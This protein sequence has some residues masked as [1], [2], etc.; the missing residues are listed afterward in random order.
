VEDSVDRL[1]AAWRRELPEVDLSPL[2][3]LSRI[4]R[5]ARHLDLAR[6]EAFASLGEE[7]GGLAQW[8]FDVLAALRRAGPPYE[9]TPGELVAETLVSS[10]TMTHRIDQMEAAGL[11]ARGDHPHDGRLVRVRLTEQ[12]RRT[13]DAA[14]IGLLARERLLLS[15]LSQQQR[16][17]LATLLKPVLVAFEGP[18]SAP[19]PS[20]PVGPVPDRGQLSVHRVGRRPRRVDR[21]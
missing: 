11:V 9:L 8:Q 5:I 21:A 2:E 10:G 16:S 18:P 1:V 20:F 12:G 7:G 13:V 3:V 19:G 14:L 4:S 6:R 15:G 17:W